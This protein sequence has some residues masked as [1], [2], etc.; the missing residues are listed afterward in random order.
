[1]KKYVKPTAK[2]IVINA[3][4]ILAGSGM[5]DG[6]PVGNDYDPDA[7]SYSK[8]DSNFMDFIGNEE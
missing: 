5:N 7:P 6:S 1:M 2:D 8:G 4:A 3:N